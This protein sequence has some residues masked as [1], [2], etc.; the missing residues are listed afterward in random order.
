MSQLPPQQQAPPTGSLPGDLRQQSLSSRLVDLQTLQLPLPRHWPSMSPTLRRCTTRRRY[1]GHS[2]RILQ[3]SYQIS[4]RPLIRFL[5]PVL[6]LS[7]VSLMLSACAAWK[8]PSTPPT[9]QFP[10]LE[11]SLA[12]PCQ[13]LVF[14]SLTDYDSLQAWVQST[15]I[16]AYVQCA[17]L[18][19]STVAAWPHR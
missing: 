15:L 4:M 13:S 12:Q 16:P 19:S 17:Q 18:H 11:P 1:S 10:P 9:G 6:F 8:T 5:M 7:A 2:R 3:T 14:P